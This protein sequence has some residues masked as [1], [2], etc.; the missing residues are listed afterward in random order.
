MTGEAH[1]GFACFGGTVTIHVRGESAAAGQRAAGEAQDRLLEAHQRLSRFLPEGELSRLNRDPRP[2]VPASPLLLELARA[3]RTAGEYSGGLVDA[4]LLGEIEHAGY[5][6]SLGAERPVSLAEALAS[7]AERAP[8][9]PAPAARWRTVEVDAQAGAIMR[10]PG[11]RIDGGGIAKGLL[12]DLVAAGLGESRAFAVDCCGD[13][14][15]G[16]AAGQ[17][18][19]VLVED[20][21]GGGPLHELALRE[22]AVATSGIGRRCWRGPEGRVAHHILDPRSGEP[23]FTGLVQATALASSALVAEAYA[24]AALLSG[25][26]R[27]AEWLPCGGV[28]VGEDGGVEVVAATEALVSQAVGR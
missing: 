20:P 19:R 24:K 13:R 2:L 17:P 27:G 9:G 22:G 5:C 1:L 14:R 23:A 26:E 8:A 28:L 11:L 25:P 4:T 16:G 18:R 21:F 6:E 7:R 3:V 10:P 15:L 12:A